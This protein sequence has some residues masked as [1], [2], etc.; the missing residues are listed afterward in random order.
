MIEFKI[1]TLTRNWSSYNL[2]KA[3]FQKEGFTSGNTE[4]QPYDNTERNLYEPYQVLR[5]VLQSPRTEYHIFCHDDVRLAEGS[6]FSLLTRRLADL[7]ERDPNWA[8]AGNAGL[9]RS[10]RLVLQVFDPHLHAHW[11]GPLPM[12]VQVL[13]ENFLILNP[14]AKITL[15]KGLSGFHLYAKDLCLNATKAGRAN[16][17]IRFPM[18]HLSGGQMDP[19][20]YRIKREFVQTWKDQ[21]WWM[22]INPN[23]TLSR[24]KL[25]EDFGTLDFI[26]RQLHWF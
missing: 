2:M 4:F 11:K 23:I 1:H 13:D 9:S 26:R 24:L 21:F 20:Y 7:N 16:Y 25:I 8:V 18:I 5:E 19:E 17:V 6:H 10:G 14:T 12:R 15:S 3:S 22:P